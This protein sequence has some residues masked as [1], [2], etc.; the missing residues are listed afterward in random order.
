MRVTA[1]IVILLIFIRSKSKITTF[2]GFTAL[3][4][5][6]S[7]CDV[8]ASV[9]WP[10]S[11]LP[12]LPKHVWGRMCARQVSEGMSQGQGSSISLCAGAPRLVDGC[13]GSVT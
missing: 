8:S 5:S 10:G 2:I 13:A 1:I 4:V 7:M 12:A 6:A 3:V 11:A 9:Q